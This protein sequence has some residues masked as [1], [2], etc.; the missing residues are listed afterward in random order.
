MVSGRA[1]CLLLMASIESSSFLPFHFL[2]LPQLAPKTESQPARK[3]EK[4]SFQ[5]SSIT[6]HK[7]EWVWG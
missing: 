1:K 4:C 2:G 3:S 7:M 6:E 5:E